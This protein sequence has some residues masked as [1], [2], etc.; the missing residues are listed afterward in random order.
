MVFSFD[1]VKDPLGPDDEAVSLEVDEDGTPKS[2]SDSVNDGLQKLY[3]HHNAFM[4]VLG[5]KVDVDVETLK[6]TMYDREG[7]KMDPNA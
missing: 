2:P 7:N 6:L 4:K 3:V 1:F 5:G